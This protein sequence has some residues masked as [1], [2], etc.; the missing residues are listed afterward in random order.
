MIIIS[1][2]HCIIPDS[3]ESG[4]TEEKRRGEDKLETAST[5][6]GDKEKLEILKRRSRFPDRWTCRHKSYVQKVETV[7][8]LAG[9]EK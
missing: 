3:E 7:H 5:D 1:D 6:L 8:K 4:D 2:F 9:Y